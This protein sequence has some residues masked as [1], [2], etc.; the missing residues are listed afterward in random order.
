MY[1]KKAISYFMPNRLMAW[2]NKLSLAGNPTRYVAVNDLVKAVKKMEIWK[3]KASK[4][5]RAMEKGEFEQMKRILES[6]DD[7]SPCYMYPTMFKFKFH[8]VA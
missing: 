2:N 5:D 4:A 8:M 6:F 7:D 1:Y 3:G